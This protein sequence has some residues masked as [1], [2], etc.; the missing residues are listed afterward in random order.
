MNF[1][2]VVIREIIRFEDEI[3]ASD[4]KNMKE[5]IFINRWF[6]GHKITLD[7][8]KYLSEGIFRL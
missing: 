2:G 8:F 4:I 6:G 1:S 3:L 5:L 7:V